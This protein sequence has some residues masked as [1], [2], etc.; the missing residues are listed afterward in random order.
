METEIEVDIPC[1][2]TQIDHTGMPWTFM[3]EAAHPDRVGQ[4]AIVITGDAED[5][6]LAR[7]ASLTERPSGTK[8]HLEILPGDPR[9]HA[10]AV[11]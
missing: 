11:R 10:E 3:D 7:V 8:V 5:P 9:D 6:V 1:D 2:P 4:G